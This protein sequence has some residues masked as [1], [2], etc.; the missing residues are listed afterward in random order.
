MPR[1]LKSRSVGLSY[2]ADIC[3]EVLGDFTGALSRTAN[4]IARSGSR[5]FC[6]ADDDSAGQWSGPVWLEQKAINAA[7]KATMGRT[8]IGSDTNRMASFT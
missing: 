6:V 8:S 1:V 3:S 2:R 7:E 5:N 4:A